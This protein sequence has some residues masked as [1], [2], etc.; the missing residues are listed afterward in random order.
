MSD[1]EMREKLTPEQYRVT[2]ENGTERAFEN[3]YWDNHR[4]G[5]YVDVVSGAPLFA[6]GHNAT[7]PARR[8]GLSASQPISP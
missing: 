5:V 3:E 8:S 1:E 4:P 2:Q 6:S 7:G